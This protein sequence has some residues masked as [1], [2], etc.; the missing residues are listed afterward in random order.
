MDAKIL[1]NLELL[2]GNGVG[3]VIILSDKC[4]TNQAEC[5]LFLE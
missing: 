1:G 3:L 4:S 2:G 5:H